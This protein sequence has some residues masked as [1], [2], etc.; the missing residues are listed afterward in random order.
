MRRKGRVYAFELTRVRR[1]G[2]WLCE[3]KL[4]LVCKCASVQTVGAQRSAPA[5]V[6][7]GGGWRWKLV[8]TV[9][10][11]AHLHTCTLERKPRR[12]GGSSPVCGK[13]GIV[14]HNYFLDEKAVSS[15]SILI[16][17]RQTQSRVCPCRAQNGGNEMSKSPS[18]LTKAAACAIF[19]PSLAAFAA[20]PDVAVDY[21]FNQYDYTAQADI[22]AYIDGGHDGSPRITWTADGNDYTIQRS[23]NNGSSWEDVTV[24]TGSDSSYVDSSAKIAKTYIYRLASV[25][26]GG[27]QLE[28]DHIET[29]SASGSITVM[30]YLGPTNADAIFSDGEGGQSWAWGG[31]AAVL[32]FDGGLNQKSFLD[33]GRYPDYGSTRDVKMGIDFGTA[34]RYV[35]FCRVVPR[36]A[37]GQ[38]CEHRINGLAVYG[39]GEDWANTGVKISSEIAGVTD[40][41]GFAWYP[42]DVD[43]STPY[44]CFYVFGATHGNV[45][46][47]E[48]WGWTAADLAEAAKIEDV[49]FTVD[50]TDFINSYAVLTFEGSANGLT[51]QRRFGEDGEWTDVGTVSGSTFTDETVPYGGKVYYRLSN[52]ESATSEQSFV[53]MH[54]LSTAGE[55]YFTDAP[56]AESWTKPVAQSFD[57]DPSTYADVDLY[58]AKIGVDFGSRSVA[59]AMVRA[60]PRGGTM[61]YRM[62][63]ALLYGS[64]KGAAEESATADRAVALTET[65]PTME[66]GEWCELQVQTPSYYR[67]YYI[68]KNGEFYG[69]I[70]EAEFYGWTIDEVENPPLGFSVERTSLT[71]FLP[72]FTWNAIGENAQL[73]RAD[74]AN[75]PWGTLA[76][77]A[78]S[79]DTYYVDTTIKRYGLKYFYRLKYGNKTSEVVSFRR[80]RKISTA[81]AE[82]FTNATNPF[83]PIANAFDGD[84]DAGNRAEC[85]QLPN[86]VN[87]KIGVDLKREDV[88]VALVRF[89]PRHEW[90]GNI[91]LSAGAYLYG[92][93]RTAEEESADTTL[94]TR[95][96]DTAT[97]FVDYNL[98]WQERTVEMPDYYRTYY[99][100]GCYNANMCEVELYGWFLSDIVRPFRVYIR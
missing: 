97:T 41:S 59:V 33:S 7:A 65:F 69:N 89:Y 36:Y 61:M 32:A 70:A 98:E 40:G 91:R 12:G 37:A 52:G 100:Q 78:A 93:S 92:S 96:T 31:K 43:S 2:L 15:N 3:P 75:G 35:V 44:R 58:A 94:A 23:S 90:E 22:D 45:G 49:T 66:E 64:V 53:R 87:P 99:Y 83:T 56:M 82:V 20:V 42:L 55:T 5:P 63:N 19:A 84:I 95:L 68:S 85:E 54:R 9:D 76:T 14:F 13:R 47:V 51:V 46:E 48:F 71:E 16:Q 21:C 38:N 25:P 26:Q 50:R 62:K 79:D 8:L 73:Q 81:D 28:P 74:N 72:A 67:S 24:V 27:D 10:A 1:H 11:F 18:L 88:A 6:S 60:T 4:P 29:G 57:G 86:Y 39:A 80:L 34:D 30:R 17:Y 77:F